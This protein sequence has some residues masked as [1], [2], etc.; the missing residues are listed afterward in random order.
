M[1]EH[2][3][4]HEAFA[5]LYP[6]VIAS[7]TGEIT[8]AQVTRLDEL[9]CGDPQAR[10]LYVQLVY[11]SVNLRTWAAS[12]REATSDGATTPTF[13]ARR[14]RRLTTVRWVSTAAVASLAACLLVGW[15]F[16]GST[17]HESPL[18]SNQE[19]ELETKAVVAEARSVLNLLDELERE[20]DT[21]VRLLGEDAGA[22]PEETNEEKEPA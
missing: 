19:L 4:S 17:E 21:I 8:P 13:V 7:L 10:R 5:E 9:V 12:P 11:E 14:R 18:L 20:N 16:L 15:V 6:L 1:T 3:D 22:E 2:S